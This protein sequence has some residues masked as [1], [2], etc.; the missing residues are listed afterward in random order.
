MTLP[1][2]LPLPVEIVADP[3]DWLNATGVVIAF[4]TLLATIVVPQIATL[5]QRVREQR[6]ARQDAAERQLLRLINARLVAEAAARQLRFAALTGLGRPVPSTL[7]MATRFRERWSVWIRYRVEGL[8]EAL[9]N[10]DNE[11]LALAELSGAQQTLITRLRWLLEQGGS[12][13][14]EFDGRVP[15]GN[16]LWDL[17]IDIDQD[18]KGAVAQFRMAEEVALVRLRMT[19]RSDEFARR[20]IERPP[21]AEEV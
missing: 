3:F 9:R 4:I 17:L 8:I 1:I 16:P 19:M 15:D 10:L 21:F 14:A 11:T 2:P 7:G 6:K 20:L 18:A 13:I 12:L 5:F